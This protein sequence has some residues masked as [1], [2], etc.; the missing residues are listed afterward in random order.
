MTKDKK[1]KIE[2]EGGNKVAEPQCAYISGQKS[3]VVLKN[4]TELQR[5]ISGT[6]LVN[7]LRPR[8]QE[9]FEK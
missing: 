3:C 1:Y 4:D 7:R 9:L 2:Q 5:A 6:E 8:I